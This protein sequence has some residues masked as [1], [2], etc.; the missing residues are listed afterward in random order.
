MTPQQLQAFH[1]EIL[2]AFRS[3]SPSAAYALRHTAEQKRQPGYESDWWLD[4]P[5]GCAAAFI[6]RVANALWKLPNH[7][8][9]NE[10]PHPEGYVFLPWSAWKDV[11]EPT[12]F[13]PS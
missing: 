4:Y 11:P 3:L 8:Q 1:D 10:Y 2:L 12:G 7:G 9:T 5:E 13:C 6:G